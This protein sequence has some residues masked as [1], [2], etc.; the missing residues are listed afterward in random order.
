MKTKIWDISLVLLSVFTLLKVLAFEFDVFDSLFTN[1]PIHSVNEGVLTFSVI[2]FWVVLI[3]QLRKISP[4][5]FGLDPYVETI[6][7][8][9]ASIGLGAFLVILYSVLVNR[10][11]DSFA[12]LYLPFVFLCVV[13]FIRRVSTFDSKDSLSE[14]FKFANLPVSLAVIFAVL[15]VILSM[16]GDAV[17]LAFYRPIAHGD[18]AYFWWSSSQQL[19]YLGYSG[20]IQNFSPS[21]YLPGYPII[22]QFLIGL[23]PTETFDATSRALPFLHGLVAVLILTLL[24]EFFVSLAFFN[25]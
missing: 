20:Y 7:G 10:P 19:N 11:V 5:L 4:M 2:L 6:F 12:L 13:L 23:A 22:S 24:H 3:S 21:N 14:K 15:L 8:L 1:K 17:Y 9:L 25:L 16:L 18:E